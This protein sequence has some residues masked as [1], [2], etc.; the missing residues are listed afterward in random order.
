MTLKA[1]LLTVP[2]QIDNGL[3]PAFAMLLKEEDEV[4][5]ARYTKP[6]QEA[7]GLLV[8]AAAKQSAVSTRLQVVAL[9]GPTQQ[10]APTTHFLAANDPLPLRDRSSSARPSA[11]STCTS[12][13]SWFG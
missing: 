8:D 10:L 1:A 7:I 12:P 4:A 2:D 6:L 13:R 9:H 5:Q 11:S 3:E